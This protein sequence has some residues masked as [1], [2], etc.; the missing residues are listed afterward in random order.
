MLV[1]A[2]TDQPGPTNLTDSPLEF[3][4]T[5]TGPVFAV[6]P[7]GDLTGVSDWTAI[8]AAF[9][10]GVAAGPGSIVEL[11]TGDF[12]IHKTLF[13]YDFV[14]TLR[15]QGRDQTTIRMAPGLE[16]ATDILT[17]EGVP[18]HAVVTFEWSGDPSAP[19]G[20]ATVSDLGIQATEHTMEWSDP[21]SPGV[22]QTSAFFG[23]FAVASDLTVERVRI[24]GIEDPS[25]TP[26]LGNSIFGNFSL[27]AAIGA[28]C[29][30]DWPPGSASAGPY[31]VMVHDVSINT[32]TVGVTTFPCRDVTIG[33]KR[34]EV[35][36]TNTYM[37]VEAGALQL[38]ISHSLLEGRG[39]GSLTFPGTSVQI[40]RS[41]LSSD[42]FAAVY[43]QDAPRTDI[44]HNVLSGVGG[45]AVYPWSDLE[46]TNN[47]ITQVLPPAP[48][49][50]WWAPVELGAGVDAQ[51][52]ALIANN[53]VSG[54]PFIPPEQTTWGFCNPWA[55]V[56][57]SP[58][59]TSSHISIV[60]NSISSGSSDCWTVQANGV[61]GIVR[62]NQLDGQPRL[63]GIDL[64][65][66]SDWNIRDNNMNQ[67]NACPDIYLGPS[68]SDNTVVGNRF[69]TVLDEGINNTV[70]G[71]Q[72]NDCAKPRGIERSWEDARLEF[73]SKMMAPEALT[74]G[75]Y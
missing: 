31:D 7:S 8:M 3:A 46:V 57:L 27:I 63:D 19:E 14:G 17:P 18:F 66:G 36:I 45:V 49:Q 56:S 25:F 74:R 55:G 71:D 9:D 28:F 21:R 65:F 72:P 61:E 16:F 64:W 34:R 5:A 40:S 33:E 2:C 51:S 68:A 44:S 23:I 48:R 53:T 32:T 12:Y 47:Q 22:I 67:L 42:L 70:L 30:R 69:T 35:D 1:G 24:E 10:D 60:S 26:F 6:M 50:V 11:G 4:K 59:T 52:T 75:R 38:D 15:G 13:V 43:A 58:Q 62:S 37:A 54:I 41:T 29:S 20:A 39:W 73:E